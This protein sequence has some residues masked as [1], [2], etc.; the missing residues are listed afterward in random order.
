MSYLHLSPSD[1]H[2]ALRSDAALIVLD[3]R[4]PMEF[5]MHRI[6]GAV[7]LPVGELQA[8]VAELDKQKSYLVTCE[9][10]VR[11]RMACDFLS[12]LGFTSLRNLSGGMANWLAAGLPVVRG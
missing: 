1:G 11:S 9:H 2:A 10:G 8:R 12:G 7:L 4:T 6:E 3:V 5:A